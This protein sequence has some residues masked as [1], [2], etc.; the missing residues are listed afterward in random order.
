M[1][2][3]FV[4]Q[5]NLCENKMFKQTSTKYSL[6]ILSYFSAFSDFADL[7]NFFQRI[8]I[9][10]CENIFDFVDAEKL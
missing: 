5:I 10:N 2:F 8:G 9:L 7:F 4:A 1:S 3:D 6:L